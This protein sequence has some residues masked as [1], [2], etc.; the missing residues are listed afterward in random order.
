MRKV[1][2]GITVVRSVEPDEPTYPD[3]TRC[4]TIAKQS[5]HTD[6][7]CNQNMSVLLYYALC[8]NCVRVRELLGY[9]LTNTEFSVDAP[10]T[11][12]ME[13]VTRFSANFDFSIHFESL[14]QR[15][16]EILRREIKRKW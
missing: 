3:Y 13:K 1:E 4:A 6:P 5:N 16:R 12:Q 15:T 2:S 11:F 14:V 7:H 8:R 9:F 10:T